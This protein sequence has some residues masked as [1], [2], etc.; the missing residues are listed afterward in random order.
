[1]NPSVV[2]S[3]KGD[4]LTFIAV[5]CVIFNKWRTSRLLRIEG[6]EPGQRGLAIPVIG[7]GVSDNLNYNSR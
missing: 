4:Q 7:D 1:L 2:S 3:L 6:Q 5:Y